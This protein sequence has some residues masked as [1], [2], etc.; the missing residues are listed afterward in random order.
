MV[1]QAKYLYKENGSNI[2][3]GVNILE[4]LGLSRISKLGIQA[5]NRTSIRI[6]DGN[7]EKTIM[8]GST[9]IYELPEGIVITSLIIPKVDG[10]Q[11]ILID[12]VGD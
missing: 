6:N 4:T 3:L 2:T 12:Y 10:L 8:V 5:P 1:G 9:G 7:N 11:D